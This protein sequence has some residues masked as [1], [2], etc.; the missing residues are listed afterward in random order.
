MNDV[1]PVHGHSKSHIPPEPRRAVATP[2]TKRTAFG[3]MCR[4]LKSPKST[5]IWQIFTRNQ[6]S[7]NIAL[8]FGSWNSKEIKKHT[9]KAS[10]CLRR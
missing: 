7:I 4:K 5:L 3:L 6:Y 2:D 8:I 9:Q 10:G 1:V